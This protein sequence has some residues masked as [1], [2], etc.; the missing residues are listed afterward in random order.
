MSFEG[1]VWCLEVV[2]VL[3]LIEF[4]FEIDVAF[5]ALQLIKLLAVGA[6]LSFHFSVEFGR[7]ALDVCMAD[8]DVVDMPMELGLELMAIIGSDFS[9]PEW[10]LVADVIDK[11][12]CVSLGM[13]LADLE[14]AEAG[15]IIN[16]GILS[17]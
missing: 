12:D 8:T 17:A 3:P 9:Y 13:L 10:E 16:G 6:V 11:V 1:S 14:R 2:E 5:L 4:G 7:A 15:G